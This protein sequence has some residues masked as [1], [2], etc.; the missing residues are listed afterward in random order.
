VSIYL[1][2]AQ[3]EIVTMDC[4]CD[5]GYLCTF[6]PDISPVGPPSEHND[7]Y[8]V[9]LVENLQIAIENI[10]PQISPDAEKFIEEAY[11]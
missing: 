8:Q 6:G 4:L 9:V 7:Y 11:V 5:I 1:D 2:E 3:I 10:N